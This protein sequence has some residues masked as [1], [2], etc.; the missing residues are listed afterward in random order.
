MIRAS[1][2]G[3]APALLIFDCDGVLVDSEPIASRVLAAALSEAGFPLSAQQ[4]IDRYTGSS[5][6]AVLISVAAEWGRALPA[7]FA[8]RLRERDRA[9]FAAELEAM[10]GVDEMLANL[11]LR[12]CVASS[13]S[14][15][16]IRRNLVLTGLLHHFEPHLFSAEMVAV[17]K[18]APDLFLLAA[19][20]MA[21]PPARCLVVEDSLAGVR[22]AIAAGMAVLA[23]VGGGHVREG[24][25]E[26][27]LAAGADAVFSEMRDLPEL[28]AAHPGV[29]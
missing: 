18:P 6:P 23:F 29:R 20:R 27:L 17:G 25:A 14:R 9:A 12:K 13:G 24:H 10:P 1:G 11:D 19:E 2:S 15:D 26:T 7:D 3:Q 4:A 16:K 8:A 21:V 22:A 5:L 28:L